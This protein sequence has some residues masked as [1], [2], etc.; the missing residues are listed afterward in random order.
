MMSTEAMHGRTVEGQCDP[1]E[2]I[3]TIMAQAKK[4][5]WWKPRS[6]KY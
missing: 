4:C 2:D 3:D 5:Q 1:N 6:M